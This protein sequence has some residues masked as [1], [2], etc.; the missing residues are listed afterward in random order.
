MNTEAEKLKGLVEIA[1][2]AT[3]SLKGTELRQVAFGRVLEYLL[4]NGAGEAPAAKRGGKALSA[5]DSQT[6]SLSADGAFADEQQRIDE[7]ARYFQVAPEDVL[8]LFD[9][10]EDA[11]ALSLST[12][13]LSNQKTEA[14]R[15]ITLLVTGARTAL[16]QTTS[17]SHIRSVVDDYGRLDSSNFMSTL[18]GMTE[19]NLLGKRRSRNRVIRMKVLGALKNHVDWHSG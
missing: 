13:R 5:D 19:I 18:Q 8:D 9:L 2:Q 6:D 10:T 15:E 17:T 4:S 1:S 14:T 16:G 7:I 11:P 12:T 3:A